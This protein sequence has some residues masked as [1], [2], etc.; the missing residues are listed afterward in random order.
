MK[1]ERCIVEKA[2][3]IRLLAC[4]VDGVLT[5]GEIIILNNGEEIKVWN[6]KDGMGYNELF[7][8]HPRI[9]TAWITGRQS[10]QV[11]MRA[12]NM[13]IDYLVQDCMSKMSALKKILEKDCFNVSEVAYIG[14]DIVDIS[15]LKAVGLSICPMDACGEVKKHVDHVSVFNGGE[16]VVREVIELIMKAKGEWGK[17]LSSY[18]R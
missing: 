18:E 1:I 17:I 16:G 7:K 5:R 12:K 9:K 3:E 13:G 6:V 8:V 10:L 14:D 2:R 4:D 15:I 11:E